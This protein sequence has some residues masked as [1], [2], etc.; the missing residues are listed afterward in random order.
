MWLCVTDNG[1]PLAWLPTDT[2]CYW[3]SN[4]SN[5]AELLSWSDA[6]AKCISLAQGSTLLTI[7]TPGDT[8][9]LSVVIL[10]LIIFSMMM[11]MMM[12]IAITRG[13][14]TKTIT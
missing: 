8:V 6:K 1:C 5:P 4:T 9:S 13:M 12:M 14:I 2:A 11:M 7:T 10:L 3:V